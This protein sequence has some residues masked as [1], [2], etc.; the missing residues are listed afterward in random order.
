MAAK[1]PARIHRGLTWRI[2]LLPV[3]AILATV[4]VQ[5][6]LGPGHNSAVGSVRPATAAA[7][8]AGAVSPGESVAP[9]PGAR[10]RAPAG[11]A[12]RGTRLFVSDVPTNGIWI[13]DTRTGVEGV[14]AGSLGPGYSG[15]GGRAVDAQLTAPRGVALD[16]AGDLFVADSGNHAVRKIDV[17]G[18]ITT[19]AGNGTRG[20]S[21]DG[22]PAVAAQLNTPTA[23]AI[24]PKGNLYIADT[25]N[26]RIRRVDPSG[27]IETVAGSGALSLVGGGTGGFGF[28]GDGGPAIEAQLSIPEGVA[29]DGQGDVFIADTGNDRV[30]EVDAAGIIRTIAGT[31]LNRY[32]GDGGPA[33]QAN[34]YA[35]V[36]I[37]F[38]PS[39]GVYVSER[40]HHSVRVITHEGAIAAVAGTGGV[41]GDRGDGGPALG[42]LLND[43]QGIAF[44]PGGELYVA[45]TGNRRIRIVLPP[46]NTIKSV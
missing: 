3:A 1:A 15:D 38:G 22:G 41:R 39:G 19:V 9:A 42:A 36:G 8:A 27:N 32:S 6:V 34:L 30:R 33:V 4:V 17:S 28:S 24:D 23:V 40:D 44:G 11:V 31:G 14:I 21:G 7:Q 13:L 10:F 46:A 35:P 5:L 29:V 12:V 16:A 18:N 45:D 37:A 20:Y 26:H 25:L 43:P 2:A